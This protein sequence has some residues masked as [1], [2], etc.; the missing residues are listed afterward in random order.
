MVNGSSSQQ[1]VF[2]NN[3]RSDTRHLLKGDEFRD[4]R[5]ERDGFTE[6]VG[7][8]FWVC[9]GCGAGTLESYYTNDG[10]RD[11]RSDN[12]L[13]DSKYYP[14]RAA[15]HVQQ[16]KFQKIPPK[17]DVIYRETLHAYNN[18]LFVLCAVGLR[19]LLEGICF[20]KGITNGNLEKKIEKLNQFIPQSIVTHLHNLRFFGNDAAHELAA[21]SKD[22]L[23]IAIEICEDLLNYLYELDYKASTLS[24]LRQSRS[25]QKTELG[26]S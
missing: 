18:R 14:E 5:D 20:D 16:K 19:A 26:S 3:C 22:E 21:P 17:L 8:R 11:D 24:S 1:Y 7:S 25:A 10:M 9:A 13:Y 4:Y 12:Q 6:R 2:C 23:R 15:Y